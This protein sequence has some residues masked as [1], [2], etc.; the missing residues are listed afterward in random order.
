MTEPPLL[1]SKKAGLKFQKNITSWQELAW[2]RA[3]P[4]AE[5]GGAKESFIYAASVPSLAFVFA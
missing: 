3:T 4:P 2:L 5:A 1:L